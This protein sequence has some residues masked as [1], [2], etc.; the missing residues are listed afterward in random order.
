MHQQE[1]HAEGQALAV[2]HLRVQ[3]AVGLQKVKQAALAGTQGAA[4]VAVSGKCAACEDNVD[5]Y[6]E[7]MK[8]SYRDL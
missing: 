3:D 1:T 2:A 5:L 8:E 7:R 6:K 4:E